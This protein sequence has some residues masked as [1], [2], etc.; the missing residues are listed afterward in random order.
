L[1]R[2]AQTRDRNGQVSVHGIRAARRATNRKRRNSA[3]KR[4]WSQCLGERRRRV[5]ENSRADERR[6]D[7]DRVQRRD[8]GKLK[9]R[10]RRYDQSRGRRVLDIAGTD[11][12]DRAFML[13]GFRVRMHEL[14]PLRRDTQRQGQEKRGA[15]RA[16][17]NSAGQREH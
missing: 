17:D 2:H 15:D 9:G 11:K 16:R 8:E 1:L 5:L 3:R 4:G 13:A 10:R 7:P 6:S 14:V 12:S